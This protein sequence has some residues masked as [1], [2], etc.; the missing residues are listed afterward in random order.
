VAV[1]AAAIRHLWLRPAENV[2][3]CHLGVHGGPRCSV[4][5]VDTFPE[6]CRRQSARLR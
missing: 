6:R 5:V 2:A 1:I 3:A 4:D